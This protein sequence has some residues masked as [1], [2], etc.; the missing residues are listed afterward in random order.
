MFRYFVLGLVFLLLEL[1][2]AQSSIAQKYPARAVRL[3]VNSSPGGGTDVAA[4]FLAE[5]LSL[6]FK[7]NFVVENKPGAS[8][9]V[10][11]SAVA[12]LRPDGY[13]LLFASATIAIAPFLLSDL[14]V[15]VTR[16]LTPI[17]LVAASPTVVAV[18]ARIPA[19]NPKELAAWIKQHPNE[20]RWGTSGI[21]TP[22]HLGIELFD[23]MAGISPMIV[24]YNGT[25]P[26]V[27]AL[28]AGDIGG[29][30]AVSPSVK[31]LVDTGQL[32]NLGVTSAEPV[33][34]LP[35]VPTIASL[36]FPGFESTVW[37]GIFGPANMPPD[38]AREIQQTIQKGLVAPAFIEKLRTSGLAV[39]ISKDPADFAAYFRSEIKKYQSLVV[40]RGIRNPQ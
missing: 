3:I 5:Q 35:G 4:R 6:D 13:T 12:P 37:F 11:A 31:G 20:F 23:K 15:D 8:G 27:A 19:S 10:G 16:D 26:S 22:D 30:L 9:M 34:G 18:N 14:P 1:A 7:Q 29:I 28:L 38:L 24:P 21:G 33:D 40:E 36:G 39:R 17:T 2:A 32:K 25:G